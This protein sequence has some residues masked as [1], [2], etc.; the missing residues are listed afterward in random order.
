MSDIRDRL[1]SSLS[2]AYAF[3][4]ELTGGGMSRV[5]VAIEHALGRRVVLK[6]L[7]PELA[8]GVSSDRFTREIRLAATLQHPNIVPL[9]TAG[10]VDGLPFYVMPFVEGESLRARL[11]RDGALSAR[12]TISIMRDVVSRLDAGTRRRTRRGNGRRRTGWS[13]ARRDNIR[14]VR[15]GPC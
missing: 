6:V 10:V 13:R 9:L 11:I 1:Q 15:S 3:E 2:S 7:S 12:E 8:T 14:S 4:R 5:F